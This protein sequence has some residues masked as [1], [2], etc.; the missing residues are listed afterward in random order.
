MKVITTFFECRMIVKDTRWPN[1][2][3]IVNTTDK[4]LNRKLFINNM[5]ANMT[6]KISNILQ[7]NKLTKPQTHT[8]H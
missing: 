7:D 3:L 6:R 8:N 5:L 2:I 4:K 1:T